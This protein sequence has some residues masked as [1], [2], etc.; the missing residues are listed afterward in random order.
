MKRIEDYTARELASLTT[1]EFD[2]LA[3]TVAM[4]KGVTKPSTTPPPEAV[5]YLEPFGEPADQ[6]EL[7]L[8]SVNSS[9]YGTTS[10]IEAA[11]DASD[12]AA[13]AAADEIV[14]LFERFTVGTFSPSSGY[15]DRKSS[16][17]PTRRPTISVSKFVCPSD[18]SAKV[19]ETLNK[20]RL[21]ELERS[22]KARA[23]WEKEH[24]EYD[25]A[26]RPVHEAVWN[27]R[28]EKIDAFAVLE[29]YDKFLDLADGDSSIAAKFVEDRYDD[30]EK[31]KKAE[32][33]R[34]LYEEKKSAEAAKS[35]DRP[36]NIDARVAE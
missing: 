19:W 14:R 28:S 3:E 32:A 30:A 8:I 34:D 23:K 36:D 26:I 15:G 24:T 2:R 13:A 21:E 22:K 9:V 18:E 31:L 11:L 25:E 1:D 27:A 12:P 17:S 4:T 33:W 5:A 35:E 16:F 6:R 20:P 10:I 7:I 29:A